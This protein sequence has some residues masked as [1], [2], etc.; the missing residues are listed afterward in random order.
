MCASKMVCRVFPRHSMGLL[1]S[2]SATQMI[3]LST[4]YPLTTQNKGY[5]K[6]WSLDKISSSITDIGNC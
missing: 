6:F 2:E 1:C 5:V 4:L 3:L